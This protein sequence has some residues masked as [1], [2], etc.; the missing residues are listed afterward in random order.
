MYQIIF[1]G[2]SSVRLGL[3]SGQATES[4]GRPL[5]SETGRER[6]SVCVWSTGRPREESGQIGQLTDG[7]QGHRVGIVAHEDPG[8]AR[9]VG[10]RQVVVT[11]VA[12]VEAGLGWLVETRRSAAR[13]IPVSGF[14]IPQS[15]EMMIKVD[16]VGQARFLEDAVEPLDPS[17]KGLRV[18]SP[19]PAATS[20]N[21]RASVKDPPAGAVAEGVPHGGEYL[22]EEA[23]GD[24]V[25]THGFP[26]D[27]APEVLL[28]F[29][30]IEDRLVLRDRAE[31]GLEGGF[32]ASR[33]SF[34]S[35]KPS[36]TSA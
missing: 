36:R 27:L 32:E 1:H 34:Q 23:V 26:D 17:W 10:A 33:I 16:P 8:P 5:P 3:G 35:R 19:V 29:L 9:L 18:G 11:A 30:G 4:W 28:P 6:R 25:F 15:E 13:K 21:S 7:R 2:E 22:G 24:G 12:D 20:S 31:G 14:S